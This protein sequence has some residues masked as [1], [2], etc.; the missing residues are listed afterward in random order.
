MAKIILGSRPKNI[1]KSIKVQLLDGSEGE[2]GLSFKYRTR[3]EYGAWIDSLVE[4]E[5]PSG[6][7]VMKMPWEK[8][9]GKTVEAN[10]RY[11]MEAVDGW[12]LD[13]D[14][15]LDSVKQFCD[16]FPLACSLVMDAYR[17]AINEGRLGN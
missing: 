9:A 5:K 8:L 12:D 1:K 16:E 6:D 2:V 3:T 4:G 13:V 10:A 15:N 17:S 11:I 14:F 7:E